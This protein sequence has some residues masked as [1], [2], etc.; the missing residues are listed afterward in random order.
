ME[1]PTPPK[2][3]GVGKNSNLYPGILN[4]EVSKFASVI[5]VSKIPITSK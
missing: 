5:F 4:A 1:R 3:R 2:V